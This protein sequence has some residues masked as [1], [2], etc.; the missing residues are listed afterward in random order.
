MFDK[1][2]F[3]FPAELSWQD[4]R[5][6]L[7]RVTFA[8]DEREPVTLDARPERTLLPFKYS[9]I[10]TLMSIS[11][12]HVKINGHNLG[13]PDSV[14]LS[15]VAAASLYNSSVVVTVCCYCD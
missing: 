9:T 5:E 7:L 12:Q 10:S 11:L 15:I 13:E 6:R 2:D 8:D 14:L 3:D 4:S 1:D